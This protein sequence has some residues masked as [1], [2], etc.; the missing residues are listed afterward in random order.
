MTVTR[1]PV[2]ETSPRLV[3]H[4]AAKSVGLASLLRPYAGVSIPRPTL[5][6]PP[7]RRD[8]GPVGRSAFSQR[9]P[10]H[11]PVARTT[12]SRQRS[13]ARLAL[14]SLSPTRAVG[15]S[16]AHARRLIP[17]PLSFFDFTPG[18][19]IA[20]GQSVFR[21][22]PRAVADRPY[23]AIAVGLVRIYIHITVSD[24]CF[25]VRRK[26]CAGFRDR[27]RP[28]RQR[29]TIVGKTRGDFPFFYVSVLD[30]R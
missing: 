22:R 2:R 10:P 20:R 25:I 1:Y 12:R 11:A 5:G 6:V 23:V 29:A 3:V 13:P 27:V 9:F 28:I 30:N 8:F 14:G 21:C 16:G 15:H 24:T 7:N 26:G 19:Y 4:L 17:G 18:I